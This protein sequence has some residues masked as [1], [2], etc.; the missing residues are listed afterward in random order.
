MRSPWLLMTCL[1]GR[2]INFNLFGE[3]TYATI[4]AQKFFV[5]IIF[6]FKKHFNKQFCTILQLYFLLQKL[7]HE[8]SISRDV[9]FNKYKDGIHNS[10]V[11]FNCAESGYK[12]YKKYLFHHVFFTIDHSLLAATTFCLSHTLFGVMISV[13]RHRN[14]WDAFVKPLILLQENAEFGAR[15]YYNSLS[16][17]TIKIAVS[18]GVEAV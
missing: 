2:K 6:S 10:V 5:A 1:F 4:L 8:Q 9:K 3:I 13:I 16:S 12:V 17:L 18:A 14:L 11:G 7:W 15:K